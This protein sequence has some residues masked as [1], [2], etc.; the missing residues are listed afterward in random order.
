MCQW[1]PSQRPNKV[2]T[3]ATLRTA[4]EMAAAVGVAE[5]T[6]RQAESVEAEASS[7]V[8]VAAKVRAAMASAEV[9][10]QTQVT[11]KADALVFIR[12]VS[13]AV[14]KAVSGGKAARWYAGTRYGARYAAK[15]LVTNSANSAKENPG[16]PGSSKPGSTSALGLPRPG[17]RR[18]PS[19]QPR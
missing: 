8:K 9:T 4:A 5:R 18:A 16:V 3:V 6:I 12:E 17:P 7:D 13:K 15:A 14:S 10:A 19:N 2:A 11:A 1:A